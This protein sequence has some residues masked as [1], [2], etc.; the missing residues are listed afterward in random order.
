MR[1]AVI[2]ATNSLVVGGLVQ[3]MVDAGLEVVSN[4]SLT[5]SQSVILP[6]QLTPAQLGDVAFEHLV[7]EITT[8]EQIALRS[9]LANFETMRAVLDW[10][11]QWCLQRDIGVT[12]VSMPELA[13]YTHSSDLRS[14]EVARFLDGYA[15]GRRLQHFDGYAW[16]NAW[17]TEHDT[18]PADCFDAP[19]Q[20]HAAIAYAFGERIAGSVVSTTPQLRRRHRQTREFA[21]VPFNTPPGWEEADRITRSS[22]RGPIELVRLHPG[23]DL[24]VELS[25]GWVVGTVHNPAGSNAVLRID[26]L[27]SRTKRMDGA[28]GAEL[29]LSAWSLRSPVPVDGRA[30]VSG[31]EVAYLPDLEHNQVTLW[32]P[33]TEKA[34]KRPTAVEMAGVIVAF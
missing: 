26:G 19:N 22:S 12:F 23:N 7:V 5:Y 3:G 21:Y 18:T 17:A 32:R 27:Q 33:P 24:D 8:T 11:V 31:L 15:D 29:V 13:S 25:A 30:I 2:G 6:F 14:F 28:L 9:S 10:T 1:T 20:M 16:L 34:R 4:G